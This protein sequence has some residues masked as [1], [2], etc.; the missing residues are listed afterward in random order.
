MT[1]WGIVPQT[2]CSLVQCQLGHELLN[3][4]YSSSTNLWFSHVMIHVPSVSRSYGTLFLCGTVVQGLISN[5]GW[6]FITVSFRQRNRASEVV[7]FVTE[8]CWF[9][10]SLDSTFHH[11]VWGSIAWFWKHKVEATL[12]EELDKW[13]E[14][15]Y[16]TCT[17]CWIEDLMWWPAVHFTISKD[18]GLG[19]SCFKRK[20]FIS[21]LLN[22]WIRWTEAK[23]L[24]LCYE[25][26]SVP[27]PVCSNIWDIV[28]VQTYF[29]LYDSSKCIGYGIQFDR[30]SPEIYSIKP[31]LL[32]FK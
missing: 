4:I 5:V 25:Q 21:C 13:N 27:I 32:L 10:M 11:T 3:Q 7:G 24:Q 8:M 28:Q 1:G 15:Y 17:R 6:H 30:L 31:Y 9:G 22:H 12:S 23:E 26:F 20:T 16:E 19:D 14:S 29:T 18:Y 2:S